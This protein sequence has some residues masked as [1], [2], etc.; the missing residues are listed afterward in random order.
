MNAMG[1]YG[2]YLKNY[3]E[4]LSITKPELNCINI[5][6]GGMYVDFTGCVECLNHNTREKIK[7]NLYEK[8]DKTT[9]YIEGFGYDAEGKKVVEITG[10]WLSEIKVKDLRT[11]KTKTV[12]EEGPLIPEAHM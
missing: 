1:A 12:W 8:T 7:I 11:G 10:T 3:D 4:N 2:V 6:W 5:I 9:S